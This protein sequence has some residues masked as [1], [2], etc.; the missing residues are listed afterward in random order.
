MERA[1][2]DVS[3]AIC[4]AI[5]KV[6]L[7][8]VEQKKHAE[9]KH[10]KSTF[11]ECFP[12]LV[13]KEEEDEEDDAPVDDELPVSKNGWKCIFN[14]SVMYSDGYTIEPVFEGSV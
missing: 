4:K 10:P 3:C 7:R 8:N 6:T 9:N 11:E 13:E 12:T 5:F 2:P 1:K 14:G